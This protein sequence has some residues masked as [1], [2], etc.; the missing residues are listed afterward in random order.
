[1]ISPSADTELMIVGLAERVF[2][3]VDIRL[4]KLDAD[5]R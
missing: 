1:M 2:E 3:V 4:G 5:H